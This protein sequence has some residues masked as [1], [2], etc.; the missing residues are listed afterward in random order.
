MAEEELYKEDL[1]YFALN[2]G[3]RLDGVPFSF[4]YHEY[5]IEPY[6]MIRK[7]NEVIF[8]SRPDGALH[9]GAS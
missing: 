6:E 4:Q 9:L 2:A 8:E 3:I 1:G 5:L 7:A